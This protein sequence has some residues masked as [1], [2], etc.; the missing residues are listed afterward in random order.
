M[1]IDPLDAESETLEKQVLM[2]DDGR[3]EE[4]IRWR[5]EFEEVV[6]DTPLST[7]IAKTKMASSLLKG[8]AL[9][10]FQITNSR[11][12]LENNT[13]PTGETRKDAEMIFQN[14]TD[15]TG[16]TFFPSQNAGRIQ[17]NSMRFNLCLVLSIQR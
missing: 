9:E 1:K 3:T 17:K 12:L 15:E 14:V 6:R 10:L 7:P 4:W 8:R 11:L 2:F 13:L 16:R 5:M